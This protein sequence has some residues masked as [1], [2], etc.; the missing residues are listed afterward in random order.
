[1]GHIAPLSFKANTTISAYRIVTMVT[2]TAN[3]VKVPASASELPIGITTD[4]VLE[5]GTS[6]PVAGPGN[7]AKLYFN[8]TVG[9][10]K[11]VAS[12]NA[13]QGV[14]HVDV[15]AG[16]YVVG[17]LVGPDVGATGTIADVYV[18]PMFKA[19]P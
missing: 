14:P 10:G 17:V 19:I 1:M 2:A 11:F 16:S 3:T 9:S 12:N 7:I 13:G 6:I 4:T 15:T 18:L 8:D 5:T